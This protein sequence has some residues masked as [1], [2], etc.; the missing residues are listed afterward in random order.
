[1]TTKSTPRNER[2][3]F[4]RHVSELPSGEVVWPSSP[5]VLAIRTPLSRPLGLTRLGVHHETLRPGHRSSHPHAE[6]VEEECVYVLEG[7]PDAWIDGE[8]HPLSP[9]DVVVFTPGTGVEHS[10][11]N[12]TDRDVRLL[13][14]GERA[15]ISRARVER[16]LTWLTEAHPELGPAPTL[17]P[18][19]LLRLANDFEGG[20]VKE[21]RGLRESWRVGL[22]DHVY[23]RAS[24]F[25][26][27]PEG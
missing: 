12:H 8:L 21:D 14:I 26:E 6:P 25:E 17:E 1:M 16:F 24:E 13:V 5:E 7:N 22:V 11:V 15:A 27:E 3:A 23:P 18:D 10:I 9:D 19:A 2:P 4:I 20:K